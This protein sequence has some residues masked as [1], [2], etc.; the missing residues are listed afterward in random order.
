MASDAI[1]EAL[2]V[3]QLRAELTRKVIARLASPTGGATIS[4]GHG[5]SRASAKATPARAK[6][7]LEIVIDG[8]LFVLE[9]KSA[10]V[11]GRELLE[12]VHGAIG[13]LLGTA[14]LFMFHASDPGVGKVVTD[15]LEHLPDVVASRRQALRERDIEALVDVFLRA[16]PLAPAMPAIERDNA[17]AQA[18]FLKRWPVLTA[19]AVAKQAEHGSANRSATAS[20]WKKARRIFGIR[21]AGREVYPSFQFQEGRPRPVI[22]KVLAGLPEDMTGWQTAFWFIG[23]NSWLDGDAPINRLKNAAAVVSAAQHE[24]EEWMG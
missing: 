18:A 23:A 5:S 3:E 16:E 10:H 4:I 13:D 12:A 1:L 9:A 8:E 7:D 20:R 15:V 24:R 22:A 17:S 11:S 21:V 19:E 14:K 2:P 6:A